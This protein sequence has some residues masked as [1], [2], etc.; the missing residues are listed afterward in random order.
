MKKY[1]CIDLTKKYKSILY[2]HYTLGG[3]KYMNT[4]LR[5]TTDI[6]EDYLSYIQ[7]D[8]QVKKVRT[9]FNKL[10]NLLNGGL[11]NGLIT[12]GAIPSLGKTTFALQVA[13][14]MA[15]MENTKVLFFSLEMTRFDIISKS[16]S[17]LSYLT[18]ELENYT[19]D[20][21][22]SNNDDVDFTTLLSKYE[23]IANNL[24]TIDYIYDIRDIEAFIRQF[25][26]L[27]K[28]ENIIVII[29]Y[30]QYILCGNN[31]NDKQVID[32]MTKRLK[33]LAK[34]LNI[35]IIEISSLNR[36]NYSGSITMESFKESGSIEYTSDILMGL[37]YV[38]NGANEREYEAKRNPRKITLSVIKNRYGA[39]GKI[40]FDFY[41]T[42][43]TFIE[44]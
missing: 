38:N 24:Y 1:R 2:N 9:G 15:S 30:L 26:D 10:D 25:N 23:P 42:Y 37:E 3:I 31:G 36:T 14:N 18:D 7:D 20:D 41:T 44:K 40:N 32:T 11:P 35:C 34:D 22:L 28:N 29:D 43:H 16:L 4:E 8:K 39:L 13:D 27:H 33:E 19:F 17:R 21:L 12:L 6:L 5:N